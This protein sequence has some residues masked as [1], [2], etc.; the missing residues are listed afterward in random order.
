MEFVGILAGLVIMLIGAELLVRGASGLASSFR[1][2]PLFVE[3]TI[4]AFGTVV[5]A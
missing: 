2:Q 1:M 3:L 4:V 5:M